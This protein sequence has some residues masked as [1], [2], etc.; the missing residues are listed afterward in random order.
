MSPSTDTQ[1]D[2]HKVQQTTD[3]RDDKLSVK[4][5]S[6]SANKLALNS[7]VQALLNS[8]LRETEQFD[9]RLDHVLRTSPLLQQW[10]SSQKDAYS[11][12]QINRSEFYTSNEAYQIIMIHLPFTK[13]WIQA[14]LIYYSLIGQHQYSDHFAIMEDSQTIK[15]IGADELIDSLVEELSHYTPIEQRHAQ[16]MQMIDR[17]QNSLTKMEQYYNYHQSAEMTEYGSY[18]NSE[19]SLIAGHPFHPFPKSSEGFL[20]SELPLYSPEMRASFALSYL[21][22]ETIYMNEHWIHEQARQTAISPDVYKQVRVQ[23]GEQADHYQLL[24]M[25]PWQVQYIQTLPL[26]QQ[27]IQHQQIILLG[28]LGDMLYPTSSVRTVWD[29]Q[30]GRGY[31][32]PLHIRITNLI[33]ENT[34]EQARRTIDAARII[35]YRRADI[36]S[37][38]FKVLT[39]TGYS[40]VAIDRLHHHLTIKDSNADLTSD[41]TSTND[42]EDKNQSLSLIEQEQITSALTVIYRP[43][44]IDPD[45]TYVVASLLENVP[46]TDEPR[47]VQIVRQHRGGLLPDWSDWLTQYT[48]ITLLSLLRV[49]SDYGISFEAHLQNS[50]I[51]FKDGMPDCYY[52]RDL[53]G[54][55]IDRTCS[56]VQE[57][58]LPLIDVDSDVLYES[59]V[60]W[61]RTGY[62]FVVN[63]LGSFIHTLARYNECSEQIYWDVVGQQL[64]TW[65]AQAEEA[66]HMTLYHRINTLLHAETLPA[67]ANF[68]SCF[69]AKGD[70][71]SFL[72]IP[73]PLYLVES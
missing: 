41:S 50:L 62:Y 39:E 24:P 72:S 45:H 23:L 66:Q 9:P 4:T 33:R 21:A 73:N 1:E 36:E 35:D 58:M 51:S 15:N 16:T 57:W 12:G 56:A 31:K 47:L 17:I 13:R 5:S 37:S 11:E 32:L 55:S 52:V 14:E 38:H 2:Q 40:S 60:A 30:E 68:I 48:E 71:P 43:Q 42:V 18:I 8:Y 69:Q 3:C 61:L 44:H 25:H 10:I 34:P 65:R 29:R 59:E 67:K 53:E 54:V 19:Q 49:F 20:L 22:V 27:A 6:S 46:T 7:T 26:I 63:H 70:Q 28:S 64:M